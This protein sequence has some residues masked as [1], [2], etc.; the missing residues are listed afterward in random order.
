MMMNEPVFLT[1]ERCWASNCS[2]SRDTDINGFSDSSDQ[3][4][5]ARPERPSRPE[6]APNNLS[7]SLR[8]GTKPTCDPEELQSDR[9][10]MEDI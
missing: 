8:D 10:R 1:V 4:D 5:T 2:R 9:I 7:A 3:Q 6:V